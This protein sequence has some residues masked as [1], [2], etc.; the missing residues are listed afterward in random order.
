MNSRFY[1]LW[2]ENMDNS[3]IIVDILM[4]FAVPFIILNGTF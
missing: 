4:A 3:R 2:L 1:Y